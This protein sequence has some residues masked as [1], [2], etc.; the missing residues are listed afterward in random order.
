[1]CRGQLLALP[2]QSCA[3]YPGMSFVVFDVTNERDRNT[4]RDWERQ[5]QG[6]TWAS[7]ELIFGMTRN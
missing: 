1:M 4:D 6:G 2:H 5:V 3:L 7:L